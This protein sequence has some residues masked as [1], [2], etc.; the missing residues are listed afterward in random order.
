MKTIKELN[1]ENIFK[2][3]ARDYGKDKIIGTL[4][5]DGTVN[6]NKNILNRLYA[7]S[8]FENKRCLSCKILPLCMG[9]CITKNYESDLNSTDV[10][11]LLES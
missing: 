8:T 3:T 1:E 9:P 5:E 10:G 7:H 11:C 6:W 2:C 4:N